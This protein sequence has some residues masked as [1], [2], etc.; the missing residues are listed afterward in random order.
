MPFS[1]N[2]KFL[3]SDQR[4]LIKDGL[5]LLEEVE[6]RGL[7]SISDYSFLVAPF[8]KAYEGFLKDFFLNM[9]M[10]SK[11]DYNSDYF[12]VGKVLNPNLSQ[13]RFSVYSK[14]EKVKEGN[15]ML[16]QKLWQAWKS[17]RN[18]IFHYFPHNLKK[19]TIFGARESV[20]MI[21][22][23]INLASLAIDKNKGAFDNLGTKN[24][25]K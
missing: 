10:I 17:G 22:E 18:E 23:A 4:A 25:L 2:W 13:R 16:A 24:N 5:F 20:E 14:L 12:R 11:R 3:S 15:R 21:L 1:V 19:L 7:N 8:A 6:A 9:N